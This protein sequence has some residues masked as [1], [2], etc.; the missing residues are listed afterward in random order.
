ML[1]AIVGG[2]L[3]AQVAV[4]DP[5]L[6]QLEGDIAALQGQR[7]EAGG[8]GNNSKRDELDRK[9]A[10]LQRAYDRAAS[11]VQGRYTQCLSR[12]Q[13]RPAAAGLT[14]TAPTCQVA[15]TSNIVANA[16][17]AEELRDEIRYGNWT[18]ATVDR[19][20]ALEAELKALDASLG[21]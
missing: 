6:Q 7:S 13:R 14:G 3:L 1:S 11:V 8:W 18:Y 12:L 4:V 2:L 5:D 16:R 9:I 19:K 17:R 15:G 20:H 10:Q 21:G